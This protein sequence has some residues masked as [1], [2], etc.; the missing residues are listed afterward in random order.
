MHGS[1]HL[2][3]FLCACL[4]AYVCHYASCSPVVLSVIEY[5]KACK[6]L[7]SCLRPCMHVCVY[8]H[9]VFLAALYSCHSLCSHKA[10]DL[11]T[12][13]RQCVHV[14]ICVCSFTFGF[15]CSSSFL[16]PPFV[17]KHCE[18]FLHAGLQD[19]V[20]TIDRATLCDLEQ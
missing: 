13:L 6:D 11:R 19:R 10:W 1:S 5:H 17:L 20:C 4:C 2:S 16:Q 18:L 9:L 14:C 7:R 8:D 12:C 3:A 15:V